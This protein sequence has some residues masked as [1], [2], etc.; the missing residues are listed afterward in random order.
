MVINLAGMPPLTIARQDSQGSY[1]QGN[2]FAWR[3]DVPEVSD[4]AQYSV[5]PAD[6]LILV[7]NVRLARYLEIRA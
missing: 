4:P 5:T 1:F 6:W 2:R 7:E 3:G